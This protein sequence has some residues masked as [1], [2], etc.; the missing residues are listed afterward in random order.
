[1]GSS[2]LK[3]AGSENVVIA[4]QGVGQNASV[5]GNGNIA[6][7]VKGGDISAN[8]TMAI[9]TNPK[10]SHQGSFVFNGT[11]NT[12]AT[13]TDFTTQIY[14]NNG[15]IINTGAK[16]AQNVDLTINGGLQVGEATHLD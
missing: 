15:L 1:M 4:S 5:R 11:K 2:S 7:S 16:N 14:A 9:G 8:N 10:I 6:L 3:V 13:K 12:V